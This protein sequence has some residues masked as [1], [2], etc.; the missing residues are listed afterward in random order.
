MGSKTF[1]GVWFIA[2]TKDHLPPHVHGF[3]AETEVLVDLLPDGSIARSGRAEA[4]IPSSAK[5]SDIR[6]ILK[7][8]AEHAR[9]LHELWEK[10]N[11]SK[12]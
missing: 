10:A 1:D 6:K 12:A 5:R 7:V 4:V 8:A 11:G 2:Y 3:Y 9:E